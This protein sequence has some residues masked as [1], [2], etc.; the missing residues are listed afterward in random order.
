M[1]NIAETLVVDI[2][3]RCIRN[4]QGRFPQRMKQGP[5]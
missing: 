4:A 2:T 5:A 3:L 1:L